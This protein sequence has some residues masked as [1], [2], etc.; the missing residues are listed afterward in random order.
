MSEDLLRTDLSLS[1]VA[2]NIRHND[3]NDSYLSLVI[4]AQFATEMSLK[5]KSPKN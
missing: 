1:S 3:D 5:P 2:I 4:S